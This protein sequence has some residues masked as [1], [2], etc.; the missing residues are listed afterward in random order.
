MK[1]AITES[2]E[3][4][5]NL[6]DAY[7]RGLEEYAGAPH[8]ADYAGHHIEMFSGASRYQLHEMAKMLRRE[9]LKLDKIVMGR[10]QDESLGR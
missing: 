6:F 5:I 4:L 7:T 1:E 10:D 9:I 3:L 2:R 8:G